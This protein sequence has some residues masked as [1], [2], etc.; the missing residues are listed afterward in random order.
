MGDGHPDSIH[1]LAVSVGG[2]ALTA[3]HFR[4]GPELEPPCQ[5]VPGRLCLWQPTAKDLFS[6]KGQV[7][8]AWGGQLYGWT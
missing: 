7:H 1:Y 3:V 8:L 4:E 2:P 5:G 6:L